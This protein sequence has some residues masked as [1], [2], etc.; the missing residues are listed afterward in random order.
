MG[1]LNHFLVRRWSNDFTIVDMHTMHSISQVTKELKL[2]SVVTFNIYNLV[3]CFDCTFT[4]NRS[5][6]LKKLN[7]RERKL[8]HV[9]KELLGNTILE[10]I[11]I[12]LPIAFA[13]LIFVTVA[14]FVATSGATT[15]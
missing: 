8:V 2:L 4:N 11:A 12:A 7:W 15:V 14:C 6:E 13:I 9:Q 1:I 3:Y 5:E 10:E